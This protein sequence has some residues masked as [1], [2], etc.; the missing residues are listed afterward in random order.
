MSL[1][2]VFG[3][4]VRLP[5]LALLAAVAMLRTT[6]GAAEL[7]S[8][9]YLLPTEDPRCMLL[10]IQGSTEVCDVTVDWGYTSENKDQGADVDYYHQNVKNESCSSCAAQDM[11]LSVAEIC[12]AAPGLRIYYTVHYSENYLGCE[13]QYTW[14]NDFVLPLDSSAKHVHFYGYGDTRSCETD[15]NHV[16]QAIRNDILNAAHPTIQKTLL[17][18]SGDVVYNG[19]QTTEQYSNNNWWGYFE[20][21]EDA[22]K[23]L[24]TIPAVVAMGNH[25]FHWDGQGNYPKY[26]YTL[27]PHDQYD[28]SIGQIPHIDDDGK[29]VAPGNAMDD[30]YYSLDY[31]PLHLAVVNNYTDGE[32]DHIGGCYIGSG[33]DS[34]DKAQYEWLKNDLK[35]SDKDWKIILMHVPI[36]SCDCS[37]SDANADSRANLESLAATYGASLFVVGHAHYY[38]H[39]EANGITQLVLGGGGATLDSD[40]SGSSSC[41]GC[42]FHYAKFH[43]L[44]DHHLDVAITKVSSDGSTSTGETFTIVRDGAT[45]ATQA[46]FTATSELVDYRTPVRFFCA[47]DGVHRG[48]QWDFDD[49]VTSTDENPLHYYPKPVESN[50][51]HPYDVQLTVK[52]GTGDDGTPLT[53]T[54]TI[55]VYNGGVLSIDLDGLVASAAIFVS[56]VNEDLEVPKDFKI[57][58]DL[59]NPGYEMLAMPPGDYDLLV[60]ALGYEDWTA[61]VTVNPDESTRV[62]P[63]PSPDPAAQGS[64]VAFGSV[65]TGLPITVVGPRADVHQGTTPFYLQLCADPDGEMFECTTKILDYTVTNGQLTIEHSGDFSTEVDFSS[66]KCE[67]CPLEDHPEPYWVDAR[68]PLDVADPSY[69]PIILRQPSDQKVRRFG[70]ALLRIDARAGSPLTYRWFEG[71]SGDTSHPIIGATSA[72][73]ATPRLATGARPGTGV[74]ASLLGP[75]VD[76]PHLRQ[77]HRCW[78]RVY[79]G[80]EHRDSRTVTV[81]VANRGP[82]LWLA[83]RTSV[84]PETTATLHGRGFNTDDPDENRVYFDDLEAYV[85][86]AKRWGLTAIVPHRLSGRESA[87]VRV[88][89]RGV[90]SNPRVVRLSCPDADV[91]SRRAAPAAVIPVAPKHKRP[92]RIKDDVLSRNSPD[93]RLQT[94]QCRVSAPQQAL[95]SGQ[96]GVFREPEPTH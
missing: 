68:N 35:S 78:V 86:E 77:A 39:T 64:S 33:M 63:T 47:T 88:R 54:K 80:T 37:S 46:D 90:W 16:S 71:E 95:G 3:R 48:H 94:R 51:Y 21:Y 20:K 45:N 17:L 62:A 70:S 84:C 81:S 40:C 75:E 22:Y 91:L 28:K 85:Q 67:W 49:G 8:S 2:S 5:V 38:Q 92:S 42:Y 93:I 66:G 4:Q 29:L 69:S 74:A 55:Q 57:F 10:L 9:S 14:S 15:F 12:G 76:V 65:P 61:T 60:R 79:S 26:F 27:W 7:F 89:T 24:E 11:T 25:D 18:H 52:A 43:V 13:E 53:V 34:S 6:D 1:N 83:P 44:D 31:G 96:R 59:F 73:Y 32:L 50:G 41:P 23:L 87:T 36:T 56:D 30:A 82:W 72:V 19:G 58:T